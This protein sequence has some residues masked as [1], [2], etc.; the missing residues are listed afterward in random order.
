MAR[1]RNK[2]LRRDSSNPVHNQGLSDPN[3]HRRRQSHRQIVLFRRFPANWLFNVRRNL[4][5]FCNAWFWYPI[6]ITGG[7]KVAAKK[8]ICRF[9][10][11]DIGDLW[12]FVGSRPGRYQKFPIWPRG[13]TCAKTWGYMSGIR[14]SPDKDRNVL[15]I[16][17]NLLEMKENRNH[18]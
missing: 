14:V 18:L 6:R 12:L 7:M 17:Y 3:T 15:S 1:G 4:R 13:W 16:A 2:R 9:K 11:L 10:C 5:R 8:A